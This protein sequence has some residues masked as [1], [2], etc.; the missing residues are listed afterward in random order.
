MTRIIAVA[1]GK[2]GVGKTTL[3]SNLSSALAGFNKSV[4]AVDGNTT[5]SNLGLYLGMPLYPRSLQDVM[6]GKSSVRDVM[7][8]HSD[9]FVVIPA[10]MSVEKIMTPKAHI[11]VDAIYRLLGESEFVLIDTAAGLGREATSAIK[12]ADE[13]LVVVNPD[14][15]S[16]TDALK[17]VKVAEKSE[18]VP[19]GVVINRVRNEPVELTREEIEAF[20]G[21]PVIG[22]VNEDYSVRRAVA[23]RSP[24]VSHSPKSLASQQFK[25][26]AASLSGEDYRIKTPLMSRLFGLFRN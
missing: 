19:I 2:G 4:I 8:R 20:L 22:Q 5:T 1:S 9:G 6:N 26:I 3:V 11:M 17:L 21:L 15:A 12:A 10:D 23:E 18:T 13:L 7:Y 25:S 14:M 16:L 24:V